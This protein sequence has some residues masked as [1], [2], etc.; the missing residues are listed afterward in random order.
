MFGDIS[1]EVELLREIKDINDELNILKLLAEDQ[2]RVWQQVFD[3]GN[4]ARRDIIPTVVKV[5]IAEMIHEANQVQE[6]V[7]KLLDFKQKRA[8]LVEASSASKHAQDAAA[9]T[10]LMKFLGVFTALAVS[11][12]YEALPHLFLWSLMMLMDIGLPFYGALLFHNSFRYLP[13]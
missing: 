2:E 6:S 5:E 7:D 11:C 10:R 8:S 9:Q 1:L 4:G 13:P 3:G 12:H